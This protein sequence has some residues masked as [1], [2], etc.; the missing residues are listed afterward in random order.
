MDSWW[1]AVMRLPTYC[2]RQVADVVG[3]LLVKQHFPGSAEI[4]L[5][6]VQPNRHRRGIGRRLLKAAEADLR[7]AGRPVATGQDPGS[8]TP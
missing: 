2:A 3:V 8:V 1:A 5:M 6:A 4:H 7:N